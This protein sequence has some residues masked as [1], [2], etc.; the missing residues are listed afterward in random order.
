MM[1]IY[2][3]DD[4]VWDAERYYSDLDEDAEDDEDCY[5]DWHHSL[6]SDPDDDW[7]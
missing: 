7:R 4:H 6:Y 5:C 2:Y 3:S 1:R